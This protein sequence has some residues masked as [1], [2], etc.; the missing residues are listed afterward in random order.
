MKSG[1]SFVYV[2]LKMPSL[3]IISTL[4]HVKKLLKLYAYGKSTLLIIY[5]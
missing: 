1:R 4:D 3:E 2:P 5:S